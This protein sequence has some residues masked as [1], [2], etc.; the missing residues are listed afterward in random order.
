MKKQLEKAIKRYIKLFEDKH[1]V[2]F[3]F[4]V[5]DEYLGVLSFGGVYYFNTSDL[6]YDIDNDLPKNLIFEWLDANLENE[7]YINLHSYAKGLRH[8]NL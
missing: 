3:E 1:S 2:C 8:S 5:N 4:A 6:V 7:N